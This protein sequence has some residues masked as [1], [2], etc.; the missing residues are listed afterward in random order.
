MPEQ[1]GRPI[2]QPPTGGEGQNMGWIEAEG[3]ASGGRQPGHQPALRPRE[4]KTGSQ[5]R[6]RGSD[7][8]KKVEG[9]AGVRGG[10]HQVPPGIRRGR[11]EELDRVLQADGIEPDQ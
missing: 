3:H 9:S 7:G 6:Q 11:P 8:V 2:G 4:K 1:Q 10:D 5:H